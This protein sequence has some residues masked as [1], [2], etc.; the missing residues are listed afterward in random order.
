MITEEELI[1]AL[2]EL[3]GQPKE[4][5]KCLFKYFPAEKEYT[6]RGY[7]RLLED[8]LLVE[9]KKNEGKST[10]TQFDN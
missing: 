2:A 1:F 10:Q 7:V 9:P 3:K 4:M 5:V 6:L 8:V